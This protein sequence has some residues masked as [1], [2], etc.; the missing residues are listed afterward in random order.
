MLMGTTNIF[1]NPYKQPE[2]RLTYNFLCLLEHM[3]G[4]KQFMEYLLEDTLALDAA[5]PSEIE[6]VFSGHRSNPDGKICVST[7][8]A[9]TY[10]VYIENK[11]FRYELDEQQLR[12]HLR[13]FCQDD[14]SLL[15]VTTPRIGDKAVVD[16]L[17]NR[18][19]FFKTWSQIANK[20]E[21]INGSFA[22]PCFL[23]SQFIEYG[24]LSGEFE[25]MEDMT[26]QEISAYID[27][28]RFGVE[29]KMQHLFERLRTEVD[30]EEFGFADVES[31][32]KKHWGRYGI[33]YKFQPK[34]DYGQWLFFGILFDP[35]D[36]SI[37]F[38][39]KGIPELS[40]FFD[41]FPDD[42]KALRENGKVR[43]ALIE[44]SNL[45][46]ED[47]LDNKLANSWRL[48]FWRKPLMEIHDFSYGVLKEILE[49]R[50]SELS[51]CPEFAEV[52]L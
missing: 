29:R 34:T 25:D 10:A 43:K 7:R 19:V 4:F 42:K 21:A 32:V 13:E 36:H 18:K 24:E 17:G 6:T 15:L 47:N 49:T 30:L 22:N 8:G 48:V 51:Q 35:K 52:L 20:L 27:T 38:K 2:N 1:M 23:I 14:N 11:T 16:K 39:K 50:L 44:L 5:P 28:I 33:E 26:K 31:V 3:D 40:L 46:Y 45:G 41:C 37:K 12:N 9:G